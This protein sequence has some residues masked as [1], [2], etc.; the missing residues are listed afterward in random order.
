MAVAPDRSPKRRGALGGLTSGRGR[1][2][3]DESQARDIPAF[4]RKM[5]PEFAQNG[6][7]EFVRIEGAYP[8]ASSGA[9]YP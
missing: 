8:L 1:W 3:S 7:D 2:F 4:N 9:A 5:L 6:R